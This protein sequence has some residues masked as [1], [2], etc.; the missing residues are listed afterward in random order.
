MLVQSAKR[1]VLPYT[2]RP[3]SL[4]CLGLGYNLNALMLTSSIR[5]TWN[6]HLKPTPGNTWLNPLIPYNESG[7]HTAGTT[8]SY[9]SLVVWV[10][11]L[12]EHLTYMYTSPS[13]LQRSKEGRPGSQE[14]YNLK[15]TC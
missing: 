14:A 9:Q 3:A 5:L 11:L 1:L 10:V 13:P 6:H 4:Q 15:T 12:L 2:A 8:P 7:L